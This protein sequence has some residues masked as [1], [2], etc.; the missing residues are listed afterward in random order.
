MAVE[1]DHFEAAHRLARRYV[2]DGLSFWDAI[3][4]ASRLDPVVGIARF[5]SSALYQV[6]KALAAERAESRELRAE[7][8]ELERR[9]DPD[10]AASEAWDREMESRL[11]RERERQ[12]PL[13]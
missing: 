10:A 13:I 8:K 11:A 6:E 3:E 12:A 4:E 7:I 1:T 5:M 9:L 2:R